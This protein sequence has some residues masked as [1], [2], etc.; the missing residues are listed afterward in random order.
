MATPP[1]AAAS[2]AAAIRLSS[3]SRPVKA[4]VSR[5]RQHRSQ[6]GPRYPS[7]IGG[8][9][10][11]SQ[12]PLDGTNQPFRLNLVGRIEQI[13]ALK[14]VQR[15]A[16]TQIERRET[17]PV[18]TDGNQPRH[19]RPSA[20]HLL[21][22]QPD[23]LILIAADP[24]LAVTRK[25]CQEYQGAR[26]NRIAYRKLPILPEQDVGSITPD[27]HPGLLQD[28]LQMVNP[29]GILAN[30]RDEHVTLR[31][32]KRPLLSSHRRSQQLT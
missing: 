14:R 2:P 16:S 29:L 17:A 13:S 21:R 19:T 1:A 3:L 30:I 11:T 27:P 15:P 24:V 26:R 9:R 12:N 4:A 28:H 18:K 7:A 31:I 23:F 25:A 6:N 10:L 22:R 5:G 32:C 20:S 8:P